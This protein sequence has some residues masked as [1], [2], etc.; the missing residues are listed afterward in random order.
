M[1]VTIP[2]AKRT[3]RGRRDKGSR[4]G[5]YTIAEVMI[6]SA[7]SLLVMAALGKVFV[8]TLWATAA[9]SHQSWAQMHRVKAVRWMTDYMRGASGVDGIHDGGDRILLNMP[10]G[11]ISQFEYIADSESVG[12]GRLVFF[13]DVVSGSPSNIVSRGISGVMEDEFFGIETQPMFH[14]IPDRACE[15]VRVAFRI[16]KPQ[17][18][19]KYAGCA[20][21]VKFSVRLRNSHG[22]AE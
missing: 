19:L 3:G 22:E 7:I 16:D 17:T 13:R 5:G 9:V 6:A 1:A 18:P 21:N 10:D 11:T 8:T 12:N 20:V 4:R 14:L 2:A 15:T